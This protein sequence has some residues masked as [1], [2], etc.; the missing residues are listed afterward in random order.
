VRLDNQ[1]RQPLRVVLDSKLQMPLEARIIGADHNLMIFTV[2]E[3]LE[4]TAA[5]IEAGAEVVNLPANVQGQLDLPQVLEELAKWQCNEV[6][7]EA[8]QTLS[9]AFVEA[10]LVDELVLFYA[11]SVLGD[12][13]K[14]MFKFNSPMAFQ[15][16]THFKVSNTEMVGED[17]RVNAVNAASLAELRQAQQR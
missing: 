7:I 1:L 13:G 2:S 6:L 3:D 15:N 17:V 14:S 8:G 4:K 12:Q 9:G 10:G 11:G 5:L 16:K